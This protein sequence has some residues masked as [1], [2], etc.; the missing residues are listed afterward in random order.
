MPSE[1]PVPAIHDQ[2]SSDS[3][4]GQVKLCSACHCPLS[5][6]S[7]NS[8]FFLHGDPESSETT[9]VC[10]PCHTRLAP[11]R[12]DAPLPPDE[13]FTMERELL[14]RAA[15][16]QGGHNEAPAP[17]RREPS[18]HAT[19]SPVD[20]RLDVDEDMDRLPSAPSTVHVQQHPTC[21]PTPSET[22]VVHVPARPTPA[23]IDTKLTPPQ[24]SQPSATA[25]LSPVQLATPSTSRTRSNAALA[26]SPDPLSDITRLR[27]RSQG[28]H[29]LYPG[30]TF[31]G[32]QKSGRNS[33]DV[34]VTIVDVDFASS[35]LCGYLRIRGLTDDWP[36]LTTYFDAEIIGSRY[37]FLTRNWGATEQDDM[38]HWARFPAFRHVRHELK[39]PHMTMKDANRGA[40]FM[41]WKEKFLVPDHRVQDINGASFAGFYYVCVDF[42]PQQSG[43]TGVHN[44]PSPTSFDP[45]T[46]L[47]SS[48]PASNKPELSPRSRRASV[49]Q[50]A[51]RQGRSRSRGV[52]SSPVATMSGFYFHQ[53]S[54]PYQQLSLVH[55]PEG[56]TSSFEFR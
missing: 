14:R 12:P 29:C 51:K 38:V 33:Y 49:N 10:G 30:A 5:A 8:A 47:P 16:L 22:P 50:G 46:Q 20:R 3:S 53:N 18:L 24:P 42:N 25:Q 2:P 48:P 43:S 32:T 11:L 31:Q 27:V 21:L 7:P 23:P 4:Q 55:V 34:N 44:S 37:G 41:R 15:S 52:P 56:T 1:H 39:K 9:I 28:H 45:S 35:H 54:E 17:P 6:D 40:V 36:E 19:H 13:Y 26:V